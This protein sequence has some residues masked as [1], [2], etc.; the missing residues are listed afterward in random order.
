MGKPAARPHARRPGRAQAGAKPASAAGP[1]PAPAAQIEQQRRTIERLQT[2][3]EASKALNSTLDLG[4]LFEI[5]L[6]MTTHQAGAERA[7]L[8]LVDAQRKELWTLVAQGLEQREIRLPF[9]KGLAGWVAES[10]ET[11]A[12]DDAYSDPRFDRSVDKASGFRTRTMLV[13]PVKDR[14]GRIV[15]VLQLL[16]KRQGRSRATTSSCSRASRSTPPSRSTTRG[17][18]RSRWRSR[19]SSVS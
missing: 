1:G 19:S 15:A 13:M 6:N 8:F 10:G 7:S 4:E 5:T 16:N 2:L 11:I 3:V 17:F 18:T 12:L 14:A 9:G